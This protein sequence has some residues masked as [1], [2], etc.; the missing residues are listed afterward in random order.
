MQPMKKLST[1]LASLAL[2][3]ALGAEPTSSAL[4]DPLHFADMNCVS[5]GVVQVR[6]EDSAFQAAFRA[7]AKELETRQLDSSSWIGI[8]SSLLSENQ[9]AALFTGLLPAQGIRV[10]YLDGQGAL[11]SATVVTCTGWKGFQAILWGRLLM[12][13][14]GQPWPTERVGREDVVMRKDGTVA[15]I[16]GSFY[17]FSDKDIARSTLQRKPAKPPQDFVTLDKSHD[18]Y[19]LL[20][21]RQ[22][23]LARFL[24]WV[25]KA[26]YAAVQKSFGESRFMEANQAV[27][28][29]RW[30]GE[31]LDDDRVSL[32][33]RVRLKDAGKAELVD[34]FLSVARE[35]LKER[36]RPAKVESCIVD[37]EVLVNAEIAGN[38]RFF[39]DYFTGSKPV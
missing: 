2:C 22:N 5:F 4:P 28:S 10:D 6:P 17:A 15:R 8:L 25:D 27:E 30:T 26:D 37:D 29:V 31:L 3:S 12:D 35:V 34:E 19:G 36:G 14:S 32:E 38:R 24:R 21:N 39:L 1:A 9:R 13:K 33:I 20:F 18:T 11:H 16:N 7:V 23:S